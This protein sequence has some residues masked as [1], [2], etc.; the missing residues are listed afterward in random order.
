MAA[1]GR[2]ILVA[3]SIHN[4]LDFINGTSTKPLPGFPLS[5]QWQRCND[6]VVSWWVNSLSKEISHSVEY[7]E[8]AKDIWCELEERYT[9]YKVRVCNCE[10]KAVEDEEQ[11]VYQFLMGMNDT[12]MQ[13][14]NNIL[15][16]KPLS[17]VGNVYN[18]LLYDEKHRQPSFPSKVSFEAP[19]SSLICKYCKKP[20]HSIDKFY[21]LHGYPPN[22]KFN[23]GPP[24][25]RTTAHVELE[26]YGGSSVPCGSDGPI[27]NK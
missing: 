10:G 19:K 7:S 16:K 25:H 4:K 15:M 9:S 8:Y 6:L 14:R 5:S 11:K 12:Y 20:R 13:T 2:N 26:S 18:I 1:E 23:K 27:E 17:S 22:F 24:P 21:K 3:L